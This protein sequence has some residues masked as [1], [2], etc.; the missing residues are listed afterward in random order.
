MHCVLKSFF[1]FSSHTTDVTGTTSIPHDIITDDSGELADDDDNGDDD[2]GDDDLGPD[3]TQGG[4]SQHSPAMGANGTT[5]QVT[6][7]AAITLATISYW[8]ALS[9]VAFS[10]LINL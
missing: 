10:S 9:L 7:N 6:T 5:G 8:M 1:Q 2:D 4:A 3:P